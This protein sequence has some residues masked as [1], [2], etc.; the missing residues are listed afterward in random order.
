MPERVRVRRLLNP[1]DRDSWSKRA[2][3]AERENLQ[4]RS[5]ETKSLLDEVVREQVAHSLHWQTRRKERHERQATLDEEG[6]RGS[7][8]PL[9]RP[10]RVGH[11]HHWGSAIADVEGRR[12][13][14]PPEQRQVHR[15]GEVAMSEQKSNPLKGDPNV[16]RTPN[17]TG[18]S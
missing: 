15:E 13:V 4:L 17:G 9:R 12:P 7:V 14:A 2:N 3:R 11:P 10:E 8:H 1:L 5:G 18:S 6:P 16:A